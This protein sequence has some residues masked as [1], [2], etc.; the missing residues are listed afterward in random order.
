MD[1]WKNEFLLFAQYFYR[2]LNSYAEGLI[3]DI[4]TVSAKALKCRI[5]TEKKQ[6]IYNAAE[7]AVNDGDFDKAVILF[8]SIPDFADA[9][10]QAT[11]ARQKAYEKRAAD[12]EETY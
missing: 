1:K 2:L 12:D 10:A 3:R 7:N 11:L 4:D 8:S 6:Q 9:N 5:Q